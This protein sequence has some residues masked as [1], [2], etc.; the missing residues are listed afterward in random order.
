MDSAWEGPCICII[1]II[2]IMWPSRAWLPSNFERPLRLIGISDVNNGLK[3][4]SFRWYNCIN[5]T[6]LLVWPSPR[7]WSRHEG[8]IAKLA[9]PRPTYGRPS[10]LRCTS[11]ISFHFLSDPACPL[12][13]HLETHDPPDG[14]GPYIWLLSSTVLDHR[15]IYYLSALLNSNSIGSRPLRHRENLGHVGFRT[16]TQT[17]TEVATANV[18][19]KVGGNGWSSFSCCPLRGACEPHKSTSE[20][21]LTLSHF[22]RWLRTT[23][24]VGSELFYLYSPC[25]L[26]S[27]SICAIA[28]LG[29][30]DWVLGS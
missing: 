5:F 1:V 30:R 4:I 10:Y 14:S 24:D 2:S 17:E 29:L 11:F 16:T 26:T 25:F 3:A 6:R 12:F 13:W 27:I 19:V 23:N 7:N 15:G 8:V 9:P 18:A 22:N 20:S 21:Q 28:L